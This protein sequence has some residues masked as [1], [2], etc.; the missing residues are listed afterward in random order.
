MY[1]LTGLVGLIALAA[2]FV[3][4]FTG[5]TAALW[6]NLIVGA[7]L[8]IASVAEAFEQDRDNLEYWVAAIFGIGA[9]SAP[10]AFSYTDHTQALWTSI[11]VGVLAIVAAGLRF[12]NRQALQ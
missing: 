7:V 10:F 6:T 11:G 3:L 4:G 1:L 8:L 2:P 12:F 9:I 5:N